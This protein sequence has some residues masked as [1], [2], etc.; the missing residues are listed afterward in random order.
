MAKRKI[1]SYIFA[2]GVSLD[3]HA[4]PNAYALLAANKNY[5]LAES[6]AF[7]QNQI[8]NNVPAF[9]G[10]VYDPVKCQ[11]DTGYVIDAYLKDLR[12]G[13]N[14]ET[15]AVAS[16]YWDGSVPQIGGDR[17][18]EIAV[19]NW[20]IGVIN[21]YI[22]TKILAPSYQFS[23]LQ[24]TS[25]SV[26]E[27]GA[28][29]RLTYLNSIIINVI[30]NGTSAL[31]ALINGAG[32]LRIPEKLD[33]ESILLISNVTRNAIMYD[34]TDPTVGITLEVRAA[35]D[36][37]FP[38]ALQGND[39]FTLLN[40]RLDT[41]TFSSADDIQIFV[42]N[43][44]QITRPWNFG[45]DAIERMRVAAP[46]A[47]L[48]ADFEYGLQPTKWQA[49]TTTRGYPSTFEIPGSDL[50]VTD[51]RTDA[52]TGSNNIGPS[53]ITVTTS[54]PHFLIAGQPITIK[55]LA[56]TVLGF[57]RAEGTFIVN[58][59]PTATSFTYYAKSKVGTVDQEIVATSYTQLRRAGFYTGASLGSAAFTIDS[60]GSAG[61]LTVSLNV[62]SGAT[63][64]PFTGSVPPV[65]APITV[66]TNITAGT[67]FTSVLGSGGT[68]VTKTVGEN[69]A[70]GSNSIILTDVSNVQTGL[71]I[72]NGTGSAISVTS[73][74]G[75]VV[76]LSGPTT[77]FRQGSNG[78]YTAIA[79][80]SIGTIGTGLS[81][82]LYNAAGAYSFL[83]FNNQ[84]T[85]YSVN[86]QLEIP[87]ATI[88]LYETTK[89]LMH[90][91]GGNNSTVFLDEA[92]T[93]F[94]LFGNAVVSTT[95]SVFGG[96][97]FRVNN[98]LG[99]VAAAGYISTPANI[100]YQVGTGDYTIEFRVRR[101][102]GGS[103]QVL[104][105]FRTQEPDNALMVRLTSTNTIALYG[106]G[107]VVA[108]SATALALNAWY[109][110]SINRANTDVV[111]ALDG[112][113]DNLSG[114]YTDANN[115]NVSA[116]L[117]IG[118]DFNGENGA[119]VFLDELRITVGVTRYPTFPF[120]VSSTAFGPDSVGTSGNGAIIRVTGI[121]PNGEVSTIQVLSGIAAGNS[122]QEYFYLSPIPVVAP[123]IGAEFTIRRAS[124]AYSVVAITAPGTNYQSNNKI[125][126]LGNLLGGTTPANDLIIEVGAVLGTGV[127]SA[128]AFS[129]TASTSGDS[130]AFLSSVSLNAATTGA[131]TNGASVTF[132]SLARI[133]VSFGSA[134]GLVPGT[135]ISTVI[136]SAGSNHQLAA[137]PFF[138]ESVPTSQTLTYSCRTTGTVAAGLTGILY[139]RSDG[140]FVHRPYDGGVQLGTGGP[141]HGSQAIRMSKKYIR[142]QSGKGAMYNTGALFAPSYDLRSI[143]ASGLGIGATLTFTVD[144]NDHGLQIGAIV[145]VTG[146]VSL[147]YNGSYTVSEIIDER[148]FRAISTTTRRVTTAVLGAQSQVACKNWHGSV[149]RSGPFDDQ[150]GI[151]FEY[152]G[153]E[154]AV[155]KRSSTFQIAGTV[156]IVVDSNTLLGTNTRF[157]DQLKV[158]DR[159][160]IKG[161]T[162]VV[163]TIN[164]QTNIAVSPDYRGTSNASNV[165][166]CLTQDLRIPQSQWNLDK[167]DG[168]G[169]SRYVV[170]VTKMQMVGIQFSWYGAGFIDWMLRGPKGDYIFCH[171]LKGNNVNTEAYMRTGNL[172][173]RY[174][175]LNE[176]AK[177]R[178]AAS[179]TNNQVTMSLEDSTYFPNAGVVYVE[180]EL[181]SYS[182][183][184]GNTLTGLV[185]ASSLTNFAAGAQRSYTAGAATSHPANSGVVLVSVT[186]SPLIS[187]WGSAY[188]IDGGFDNDRGYLFNYQLTSFSVTTAKN[189]A[190]L[191]RLAPS[192]SNAVPGDLGER[193]L[194]NRSQLLLKSIEVIG[195]AAGQ[196]VVVEGVLNPQNY[197]TNSAV[198]TG[199]ISGTTLTVTAMNS[200]IIV[201]G[202]NIT[203]GGVPA[204][205]GPL[206]IT[207]LGTG[208]GG[209]GTYTVSSSTTVGSGTIFAT[210]ATVNWFGLNNAAQGG[211]P[212]FCQIALGSETIFEGA[213][214]TITAA[215]TS[216]LN[217]GRTVAQFSNASVS[218][219][220]VGWTAT[221]A[222]NVPSGTAV[223]RVQIDTPNTGT[224]SIT[225]SKAATG[226]INSGTNFTF[227]A[228]G[229]ANPGEQ[230]FAFAANTGD[231]QILDLSDLKELTNSA[232]GGRGA[233]PNGPDVLAINAFV[234]SGSA[235]TV[236]LLLRWSEAQ[237]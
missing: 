232:I 179:M 127:S 125:R 225:L 197:P 237:A 99:A 233:F 27:A 89:L 121:G 175:V 69:N 46:Q 22:L 203:G 109:H 120:T 143:T 15:R 103:N 2:P 189:A 180:N 129:G 81:L 157:Q 153:Q 211:L 146:V 207:G 191:I 131:I 74:V 98:T 132:G 85:G 123:G 142:Y 19:Y 167:C 168:T 7:I 214:A 135:P 183:K 50:I 236:S 8:N 25:G 23:V 54:S 158:G 47:M 187:H 28:S 39:G 1:D 40:F 77:A 149:V 181:I 107:A 176:S 97:S 148:T 184:S 150:N 76:N 79:G 193:E 44:E 62:P 177:T 12:Y 186:N 42:E 162:H 102:N 140:F 91:D 137:G 16:Y 200:G 165:K 192:V 234:T 155:V 43:K 92:G 60:P 82:N 230:V 202:Q 106:N 111:I 93:A 48:D 31:P 231:R 217:N 174:E 151:F 209:V 178:L 212:S 222:S 154:L 32:I 36:T 71:V 173:V 29:T 65:N 226:T 152:D 101:T 213:G 113:N 208:Q 75:N 86:D 84:G 64:L 198:F 122:G 138:V 96:S 235:T 100:K 52:S 220:Q 182:A 53:L 216:N 136:T 169:P 94:T 221:S 114:P 105:D 83:S 80:Q 161:M 26:G 117:R 134:H 38:T 210:P 108:E 115:Y 87:G 223:T 144:D 160:V 51:V 55:A 227:S 185:R 57:S 119:A 59:V 116:P 229:Y 224:T 196:T 37:D 10:F 104:L 63:V 147:G 72:N 30:T 133:L 206:S 67:Q 163:T 95:Q 118:A 218:A 88:N 78:T 172:P 204:I 164:S 11:R 45:T 195:G 35:R 34:F 112:V 24:V 205:S 17:A 68:V 141:G 228:P 14:R 5:L 66:A 58:T 18:P 41:S 215:L 130:L 90:F 145:N 170:D 126:V 159:I 156:S 166:I 194:L 3:F 49:I 73:V 70:I 219:V 4:F 110:V 20:I 9:V 171:R 61:S 128:I 124:G 13:G 201:I 33:L 21:N 199:S 190:F 139:P 6:T 188:L 56:S